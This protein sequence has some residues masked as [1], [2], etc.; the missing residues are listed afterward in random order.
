M[1]NV[2]IPEKLTLKINQFAGMFHQTPEEFIIEILEER[3]EHDSAYK[4]TL[5]LAQSNVNKQRLDKAV[6]DIAI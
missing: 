5:Y 4:E 3:L 2:I 6:S 1:L